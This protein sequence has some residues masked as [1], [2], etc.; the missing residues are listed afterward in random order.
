MTQESERQIIERTIWC[1]LVKTCQKLL[2]C[3][4]C[5][6]R[7]NCEHREHGAM[8]KVKVNFDNWITK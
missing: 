8:R 2:A 5:I 1:D 7:D 4:S 3:K 6:Y